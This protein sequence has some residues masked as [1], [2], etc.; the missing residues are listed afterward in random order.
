MSC[1]SIFGA[2]LKHFGAKT[3]EIASKY[4]P[5]RRVYARSVQKGPIDGTHGILEHFEA[6]PGS[7]SHKN[8]FE[9]RATATG[10]RALGPDGS[11]R[12]AQARYSHEHGRPEAPA[13][14][15]ASHMNMDAWRRQRATTLVKGPW[16]P[17][18]ASAQAR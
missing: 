16:T 6:F 18:G 15:H 3:T 8:R 4:A 12:C 1:W 10:L 14:K 17:G 2:I 5:Q 13:R 9:T 7:E 11:H